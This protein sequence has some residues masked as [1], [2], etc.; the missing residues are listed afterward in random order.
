[1]SPQLTLDQRLGIHVCNPQTLVL[2]EDKLTKVEDSVLGVYSHRHR[3]MKRDGLWE[4]DRV[5]FEE[6]TFHT[7][8]ENTLNRVGQP[9]LN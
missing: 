1:M 9:T 2:E 3:L 5:D 4:K 8:I 6:V 7:V